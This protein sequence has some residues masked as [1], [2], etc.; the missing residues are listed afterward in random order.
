MRL[1]ESPNRAS[2]TASTHRISAAKASSRKKKSPSCCAWRARRKY[3]RYFS[4]KIRAEENWGTIG[5][6]IKQIEAG[7]AEGLDITANEYPYTAMAHGWGMFFPVWA[8]QGGQFAERLKNRRS[9]RRSTMIRIEEHGLKEHGGWDGIV[10]GCANLE[11]NKKYEGK[12][13]SEIAKMRGDTDPARP[14]SI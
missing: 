11:A 6:Y 2:T 13:V 1:V 4:F 12:T 7:R 9:G 14:P 3:R 8:K 5:N 10:M